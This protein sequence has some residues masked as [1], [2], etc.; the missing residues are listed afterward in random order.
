MQLTILKRACPSATKQGCAIVEAQMDA[1]NLKAINPTINKSQFYYFLLL[2][3][4]IRDLD[5]ALSM[6][7][8]KLGS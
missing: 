3:Y 1:Q 6:S 5:K 8:Y 7:T 2:S 4:F